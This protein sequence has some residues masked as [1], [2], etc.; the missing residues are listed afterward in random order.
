M[1]CDIEMFLKIDAIIE[2]PDC[3]RAVRSD[4]EI[5]GMVLKT[6]NEALSRDFNLVENLVYPVVQQTYWEQDKD[7]LIKRAMEQ[8]DLF[9]EKETDVE[10][11]ENEQNELE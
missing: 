1:R 2:V 3:F 8:L 7:Y 9:E 4:E 6:S 10:N 5:I 11:E